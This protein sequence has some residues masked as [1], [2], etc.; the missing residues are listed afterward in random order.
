MLFCILIAV[1]ASADLFEFDLTDSNTAL[2]PYAGPYASVDINRTSTTTAIITVDAFSG[3]L[4]GGAQAFDLNTNG[5]VSLSALSWTG[6][7][8]HTAYSVGGS[9]NVSSFGSFNFTLD[10]FDGYKSAVSQ[11]TFT[12]TGSGWGTAADV[13][14]P[15]SDGYVGAGHIFVI[16][17]PGAGALATG[18][19][20]NGNNASV[21]EPA[22]L[23]LLG[24][25]LLGLFGFMR[26]KK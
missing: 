4:I 22:T 10:A 23:L 18:F 15:N 2:S 12:L 8:A 26:F 11:L 6:G 13:L 5:S 9:N 1:N 25:G 19:A 16:G 14:T 20:A 24:S 7:N 3:F 17:A 21:P